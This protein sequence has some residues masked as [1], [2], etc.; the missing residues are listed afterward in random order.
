MRQ[1]AAAAG[2]D[3]RVP[4]VP[5]GADGDPAVLQAGALGEMALYLY[6]VGCAFVIL[7]PV[8]WRFGTQC[9]QSE[10]R[11]RATSLNMSVIGG[12]FQC[13]RDFG[14]EEADSKMFKDKL[15]TQTLKLP[16]RYGSRPVGNM[17]EME[18]V[19]N[20]FRIIFIHNS[21]NG[22]YLASKIPYRAY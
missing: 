3:A 8:C 14:E 17:H 11:L 16:V 5:F 12:V 21:N 6:C 10:F 13:H 9:R 19:K 15:T 20:I 7:N 1:G 18:H 22:P 4:G 2:E